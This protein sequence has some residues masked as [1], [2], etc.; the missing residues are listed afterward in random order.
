MLISLLYYSSLVSSLSEFLCGTK[1]LPCTTAASM[2]RPT[3]HSLH[4]TTSPVSHLDRLFQKRTLHQELE[5]A[6]TL[7][8][9]GLKL[10]GSLRFV[11][12]ASIQHFIVTSFHCYVMRKSLL[13]RSCT[14]QNKASFDSYLEIISGEVD[15]PYWLM[16]RHGTGR[17]GSDYSCDPWTRARY[18]WDRSRI[19]YLRSFMYAKTRPTD[20]YNPG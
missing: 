15:P 7:C 9:Q 18:F 20:V 17:W 12:K 10:L 3:G 16:V 5:F 11:S 1:E 2:G 8:T 4:D 13:D 19:K 6:T 14:G